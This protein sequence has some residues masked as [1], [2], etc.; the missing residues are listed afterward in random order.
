MSKEHNTL[1]DFFNFLASQTAP[2]EQD[3]EKAIQAFNKH[4]D[5]LAELAKEEKR[6]KQL[7]KLELIV[8]KREEQKLRALKPKHQYV[9]TTK[10]VMSRKPKINT[11][12]EMQDLIDR[13]RN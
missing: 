13:I 10:K 11:M 3:S 9:P 2:M 1:T 7:K 8:Q 6:L 12:K 5:K 4:R